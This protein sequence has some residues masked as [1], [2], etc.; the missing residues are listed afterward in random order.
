MLVFLPSG[1]IQVLT[2]GKESYT[3]PVFSS[4]QFPHG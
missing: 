1:L 3:H 4:G 2:V